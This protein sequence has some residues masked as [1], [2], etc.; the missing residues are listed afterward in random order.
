MPPVNH[1]PRVQVLTEDM[2]ENLKPIENIAVIGLGALGIMYGDFDKVTFLADA[3]RTARYRTTEVTCNGH[4]CPF[5][6][7]TPAEYKA[8]Q[9]WAD[10]VI[11][12]VKGGAL[13]DA[14]RTADPVIGPETVVL[15]VLNGITSE[16]II[17]KHLQGRGV[18]IR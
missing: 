17:E 13:K 7:E 16:D 10:L 18:V 4:I 9:C 11:F 6:Y 8:A 12:A 3:V 15:S 1:G 14:L 2:T 5:R